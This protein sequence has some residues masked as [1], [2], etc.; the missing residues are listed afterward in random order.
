MYKSIINK[1]AEEKVAEANL[2]QQQK[3]KQAKIANAKYNV[4]DIYVAYIAKQIIQQTN[5]Q[6]ILKQ[7]I[8]SNLRVCKYVSS[9]CLQDIET[10]EY[11]PLIRFNKQPKI[12]GNYIPERFLDKLTSEYIDVLDERGINLNA[13]LTA[14][15][16]RDIVNGQHY[17]Q[18][19]AF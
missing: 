14:K 12:E 16:L 9:N 5:G 10:L 7:M 6:L 15:D 13:C 17:F 1:I 19:N 2:E 8:N 3:S 18:E 11:Y 4:D